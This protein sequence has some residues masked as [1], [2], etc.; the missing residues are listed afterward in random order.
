AALVGDREGVAGLAAVDVALDPDAALVVTPALRLDAVRTAPT[1]MLGGVMPMPVAPR[2]DVVPSPRVSMRAAITS[3]LSLKASAGWYV[4]LPTL[5]ELFGDRGTIV[6][7]P[8]LLPERG[9]SADAGVVYA[10]AR[11][12]EIPNGDL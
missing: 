5:I 4:R 9:P 6:G 7:T 2:D 1:P 10:P 3:D 8:A 12:L 11:A